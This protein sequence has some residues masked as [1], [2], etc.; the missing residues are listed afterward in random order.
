MTTT[1]SP[2]A[3]TASS[4]AERSARYLAR[5]GCTPKQIIDALIDELDLDRVSARRI[6]NGLP[7]PVVAA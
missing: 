4:F 2:N 7:S 6:V 3:P 1:L 5:H